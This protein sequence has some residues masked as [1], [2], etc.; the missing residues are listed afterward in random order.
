MT[1]PTVKMP[2]A[3]ANPM[4]DCA[5]G[6]GVGRRWVVIQIVA[7]RAGNDRAQECRTDGAANL[8]S[9][10]HGCGCNACVAGVDADG[11]GVLVVA[12]A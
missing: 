3:H 7:G 2:A 1:A 11:G 10:I 12:E 9:D 5:P 8:L 4:V 6:E